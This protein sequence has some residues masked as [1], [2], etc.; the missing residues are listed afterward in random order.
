MLVRLNEE[1][2]GLINITTNR[3]STL[4]H[5]HSNASE[6][7]LQCREQRLPV[8]ISMN[9]PG[10]TSNH[11]Q[12]ETI[13]K[14]IT[15]THLP[16]PQKS[17]TGNTA[18]TSKQWMLALCSGRCLLHH[19][20]IGNDQTMFFHVTAGNVKFA[21]CQWRTSPAYPFIFLYETWPHPDNATLDIL[22]S[23]FKNFCRDSRIWVEKIAWFR[24]QQNAC[25]NFFSGRSDLQSSSA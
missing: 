21:T 24:A 6:S 3:T 9:V 22:C 19:K 25:P 12:I 8:V 2:N 20:G 1:N 17:Q 23:K 14:H 7:R 10:A 15:E 18:G 13:Q 4:S 11:R 16:Q 5:Q